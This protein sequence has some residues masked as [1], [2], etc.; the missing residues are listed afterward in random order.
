MLAV[1]LIAPPAASAGAARGLVIAAPG[2]AYTT[3]RLARALPLGDPG[4]DFPVH[5]TVSDPAHLVGLALVNTKIGSALGFTGHLGATVMSLPNGAGGYRYE[6]RPTG[7]PVATLPR[8]TYW[9]VV[10]ATAPERISWPLAVSGTYRA[11]HRTVFTTSLTTGTGPEGRSY[12]HVKASARTELWS[13]VWVHGSNLAFSTDAECIYDGTNAAALAVE[14]LPAEVCVGGGSGTDGAHT[15]LPS[16]SVDWAWGD[17]TPGSQYWPNVGAKFS[18]E[19]AG[20]VQWT[21]GRQIW[22]NLPA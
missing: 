22:F 15:S 12:G 7:A 4:Y 1:G 11:T 21:A 6:Q 2:A 20:N 10:F 13:D 17:I 3:V 8:G 16:D 14:P 5:L 18:D 19:Y 9:L